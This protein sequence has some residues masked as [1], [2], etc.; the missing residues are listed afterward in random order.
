L[1]I[2]LKNIRYSRLLLYDSLE[3][4]ILSIFQ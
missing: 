3:K 4:K 1:L 2:L